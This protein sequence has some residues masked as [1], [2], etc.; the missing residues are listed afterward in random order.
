MLG[1]MQDWPL[2]LHRIIDHAARHHPQREIVSRSIEGPTHRSTYS[3]I[4]ARALRVAQCLAREGIRP[5]D[6]VIAATTWGGYAEEV[7]AEAKRIIPMPEGMDFST[8]AAFVLTYGTSHHAL[9]DR[10]ALKPGETLLVLGAACIAAT[11]AAPATAGTLPG[12]AGPRLI[13]SSDCEGRWPRRPSRVRQCHQSLGL[14]I[15]SSLLMTA[16][17]SPLD[18]A[19]S[20]PWLAGCGT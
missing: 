3:E 8:A 15:G 14:P 18:T 16:T 11:G 20:R 1:L 19:T 10:A 2:R 6:R 13:V 7:V 17:R 5:G 12:A 9:K 4:R